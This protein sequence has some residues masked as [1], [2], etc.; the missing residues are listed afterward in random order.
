MYVEEIWCWTLWFRIT[1]GTHS[2]TI[3]FYIVVR[4]IAII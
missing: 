1:S 3:Y 2:S 4:I